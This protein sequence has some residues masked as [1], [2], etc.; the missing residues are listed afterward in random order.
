MEPLLKTKTRLSTHWPLYCRP[1]WM[2]GSLDDETTC[3]EKTIWWENQWRY[4]LAMNINEC[5]FLSGDIW[6]YMGK[7]STFNIYPIS[8]V[9]W[10]WMVKIMGIEQWRLC[11]LELTLLK[12]VHRPEMLYVHLFST[13]MSDIWALIISIHSHWGIVQN[14][15]SLPCRPTKIDP[16]I[17]ITSIPEVAPAVFFSLARTLEKTKSRC[18][19][20]NS[21]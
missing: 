12:R 16:C 15:T 14:P 11:E 3:C 9:C 8:M 1:S 5:W 6:W 13:S 10:F 20:P 18:T 21:I 2:W 4:I 7:L 17:L 19:V